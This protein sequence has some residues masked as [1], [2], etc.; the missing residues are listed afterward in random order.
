MSMPATDFYERLAAEVFG[1]SNA[2]LMRRTAKRAAF[3]HLYGINAPVALGAA[4]ERIMS[5]EIQT[6]INEAESQLREAANAYYNG[7]PLMPDGDYD[8]LVAAHWEARRKYPTLF[9]S[10]TILDRVG[11]PADPESGFAKVKHATPMLSL[12]NVFEDEND[13]C[14]AL[15]EWLAEVERK[16]GPDTKIVIEPKVDGLSLSVRWVN[17]KPV[18]VTRGDG[19]EGDDVSA[20]VAHM[21]PS[22]CR[23]LAL[24]KIELRGEIA[25]TFDTFER[26][27]AELAAKGEKLYANPRNAAAGALRLHDPEESKRRGLIFIP[28]GFLAAGVTSHSEALDQVYEAGIGQF[29]ASFSMLASGRVGSVADER[30]MVAEGL[31]YPIDGLVFKI[32]DYRKRE[33]MGSTSRAP[34]WAIALKFQQE[35]A[36][37]TV[38][39]ITVQVGRSGVLTPVAEL[40]PVWIDGST[41]S[42]AT[43][44]NEDQIHRLQLNVGDT[45]EVRKAAAII[46]EIVRSITGETCVDRTPFS[47][48]EHIDG[49]CPSCGGND[50]QKQQVAGEDGS[51][52]QCMN[53]GCPAQLAARIE[54]FASRKCL[55]IEMIGGEAADALARLLGLLEISGQVK[56]SPLSL[57]ELSKE[58]F[59]NLNWVTESGTTMTLGDKRAEKVM[60]ALERAKSLPLHRWLFALGIPTVG[61]NTSKE[62]SRLCEEVNQ[63]RYACQPAIDVRNPTPGVI[64]QIANGADKTKGDLAQYNISSHLG[65]VSCAALVGFVTSEEGAAVLWLLSEWGIKSEN[66][67]PIPAASDDKPLFGKSFVITGTLSVG[68]D[69]MKALIE[70]RGGKVSGSVSK[71]T[72][73]L[74]AGEDCGSKLD[75]ARAAGV[76]ILTESEIRGML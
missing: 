37:T 53:P 21:F 61:E 40:E 34:R 38:R 10:S 24:E 14:E 1:A 70:A 22:A 76:K 52:Y 56:A 23:R 12:D 31:N 32:D 25:M 3:G 9:P 26:L 59:S 47:L 30:A 64:W 45:V 39:A 29:I 20:N 8:K 16:C 49:K 42:R 36:T 4:L 17:G 72:D 69:E 6:K 68:R 2:R 50:I 65:P 19:T 48:I 62:V 13:Q 27:N 11:S 71:K 67:D 5:E 35:K 54:H 15:N 7:E 28:H 46:P 41:V 51:R 66:Y 57:F 33:L 44:H 55:D 75:K 18:A 58:G 73:Y 60:A 63:L 43:L 74:V